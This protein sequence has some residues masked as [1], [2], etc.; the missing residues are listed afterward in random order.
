[1][2]GQSACEQSCVLMGW[3]CQC[4]EGMEVGM[5]DGDGDG[6]WDGDGIENAEQQCSI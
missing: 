6:K 4:K 1:M 5:G 3:C 2:R